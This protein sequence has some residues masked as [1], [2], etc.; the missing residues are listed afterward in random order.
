MI[1]MFSAL[2]ATQHHFQSTLSLSSRPSTL[3][4]CRTSPSPISKILLLQRR[5]P[6]LTTSLHSS[7]LTDY[8]STITMTSRKERRFC[9]LWVMGCEG[10]IR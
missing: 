8:E 5:M 3:Q 9:E 4:L 6:A 10:V 7:Y 1:K 2:S